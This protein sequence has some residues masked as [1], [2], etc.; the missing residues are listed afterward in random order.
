V[1]VR[2]CVCKCVH[3]CVCVCKCVCVRVRVCVCACSCACAYERAIIE[4]SAVFGRLANG[5]CIATHCN[6]TFRGHTL[7][8]TATHSNICNTMQHTATHCNILQHTATRQG[9]IS[10]A[11]PR[12]NDKQQMER[13]RWGCVSAYTT[14]KRHE[15]AFDRCVA[16]VFQCVSVLTCVA[17]CCIVLQC[18]SLY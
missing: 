4:G 6:T 1:C 15:I 13:V 8:R 3:V 14:I 12:L 2:A 16:S 9:L 18:V 11:T 5:I 10:R 17:V 7:Q